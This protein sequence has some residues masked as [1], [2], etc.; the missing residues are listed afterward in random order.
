MS[1]PI[2][3]AHVRGPARG[4]YLART[5]LVVLWVAASAVA[6]TPIRVG[7]HENPPLVTRNAEGTPQGLIVDLLE[8]IARE[9]NRPLEFVFA[10][11]STLFSELRD[12]HLDVVA[13]IG[14][15]ELRAS[16]FDLSAAA[17]ETPTEVYVVPGVVANTLTDLA[18][19]RVAVAET[20]GHAEVV[21]AQLS[22]YGRTADLVVLQ[23]YASVAAALEAGRADAGIVTQQA[24]TELPAFEKFTRTSI[25]LSPVSIRFAFPKGRNRMLLYAVNARLEQEK[26]DHFSPLNRAMVRWMGGTL[27]GY[28]WRMFRRLLLVSGLAI[29]A[30]LVI[31]IALRLQIRRKTRELTL[32]NAQLRN[33]MGKRLEAQR[34]L[35]NSERY[36]RALIEHSNDVVG[37]LDREGTVRYISPSVARVFGHAPERLAGLKA[38]EL[39]HPDDAERL[40][41]HFED[42][43]N[44]PDEPRRSEFRVRDGAGAWRHIESVEVNLLANPVVAG[45]VIN[46]RDVSDRQEARMRLEQSEEYFRSLIENSLEIILI[47][48]QDFVVHYV[49]PSIETVLGY[50][51]EE[52]L[53]TMVFEHVHPDDAPTLMAV[54]ESGMKNPGVPNWSEFRAR[55]K[56]GQW[57]ALESIGNNL[58]HHSVVG[59]IVV[60]CRDITE[61]KEA[62]MV[63]RQQARLDTFMREVGTVLTE[64]D[65]LTDSVHRCAEAAVNRLGLASASVWVVSA[66]GDCLNLVASAG[67]AVSE[68]LETTMPLGE[69]P[70]GMVAQQQ[71]PFVTNALENEPSLHDADGLRKAGVAAFAA[72][73]LLVE[74]S[75]VGVA[76]Y[77]HTAP[78]SETVLESLATATRS[79][80]VAIRRRQAEHALRDSEAMVRAIF[81]TAIEGI[82]VSDAQ[83]VIVSVNH[84]TEKLFG[85]SAAELIG[86]NVRVLMPPP[87]ADEH[88]QYL[89]RYQLSGERRVMGT[90]REVRGRHKNGSLVDIAVS[91]S[92]IRVDNQTLF[93][94]I[95]HDITEAKKA[96]AALKESEERFRALVEHAPE[97][98]IVIDH[99]TGRFEDVNEN[100]VKLFGVDRR[101]LLEM[102]PSQLSPEVQPDGTPSV[103]KFLDMLDVAMRGGT[104]VFEWTHRHSSGRE[105][106][107]ELRLLRLPSR[108]R[109]L[110]RGSITDITERKRV[111]QVLENYR[112]TLE[113]EVTART[114][115]LADK[116]HALETTLQQLRETQDQLVINQKMASLGALT[117]GIA[118]EI[119]NPLNFVNN[120]ADLTAELVQ[121]LE[122]A[123]ATQLPAMDDAVQREVRGLLADVRLN[124]GKISEHGKRADSIVRSML[125]HSRGKSGERQ[126]TDLNALLDEYVKLA[127]HGMRALDVAFN[128]AIETDYDPAVGHVDVV[129]QDLS[130]V[131]LNLINNACY[132][133][134]ERKLKEDGC[135]EPK[136]W[137]TSRD[138]G[139]H[140]RIEVRDNG[141]GMTKEIRDRI[142][143]PFFTTKPAG[144]GSGLGLSISYDIIVQEHHGELLVDSSPG[145]YTQFTLILP[146]HIEESRQP[147]GTPS[148]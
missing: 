57:R 21:R 135:F 106:Q 119:K 141:N 126:K 30:L 84:A 136:L 128:I 47:F 72:Y 9:R 49:S 112:V 33:E 53:N 85:Y 100:A 58:L 125:L 81:E 7:A 8:D 98:I 32:A 39:M 130:R 27:Q 96:E 79:M 134:H 50:T 62:E 74:Q 123:L 3:A 40:Q 4:A 12:G 24:R 114:E 86:Q 56:N 80:A 20:D 99:A 108:D 88:D 117:A 110:V 92:E 36:H 2:Q 28:A 51:P 67:N 132:A 78:L 46:F 148:A 143:E 133:A 146:R 5:L 17:L 61:R 16:A 97:A 104:P 45:I 131:F 83:G 142:F 66:R 14:S 75:V 127:Y 42:V 115:E 65:T 11:V 122:Q 137:V 73:P 116:N 113:E 13:A 55:H 70:V 90:G 145:E 139:A 111:E 124:T 71:R 138:A 54:H 48:D 22:A 91:V 6:Q 94:G 59:G 102:N 68:C 87:Y 1:M 95:I 35:E 147:K 103:V 77:Y 76:A 44:H 26:S 140:V 105:F 25:P 118:H 101:T 43:L 18:D 109:Q 69:S 34:E 23:D 121:E 129:P 29:G 19:K 37:I 41:G 120:F 107:C 60:N 10:P 82:V 63:M 52:V 64:S 144:R 15:T 89:A 31:A 93:T 38:F